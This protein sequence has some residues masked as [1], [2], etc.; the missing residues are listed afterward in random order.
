MT[1]KSLLIKKE[2]GLHLIDGHISIPSDITITLGQKLSLLMKTGPNSNSDFIV[3][4]GNT[5]YQNT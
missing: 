1:K 3:F 4:A 5:K 2:D